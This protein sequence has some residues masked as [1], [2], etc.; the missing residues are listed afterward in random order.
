MRAKASRRHSADQNMPSLMKKSASEQQFR[1]QS[2]QSN[3]SFSFSSC[4]RTV[5]MLSSNCLSKDNSALTNHQGVEL[6]KDVPCYKKDQHVKS[7]QAV[8]C[9]GHAGLVKPAH[10]GSAKPCRQSRLLQASICLTYSG[11]KSQPRTLANSSKCCDGSIPH[12]P[13]SRRHW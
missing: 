5:D 1:T 8:A 10:G 13:C 4:V 2:L 12:P 7:T 3:G 6:L 11:C 9:K